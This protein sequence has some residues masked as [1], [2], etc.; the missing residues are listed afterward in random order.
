MIDK[1]SC[2]RLLIALPTFLWMTSCTDI[3]NTKYKD[4]SDLETP[5]DMEIVEKPGA[6]I[7]EKDELEKNGLADIVSYVNT[8]EKPVIKIKK[9][10]FRS[11]NI[12]EQALK[13]NNI[14]VKDK[15]RE[16]G[17]FYVLFDP[18]SQNSGFVD[19]IT[20]SLFE[21]KFEGD[22]YRLTVKWRDSDTEVR[23]ELYDKGG[24]DLLDDDED[25]D[26]FEGFVDESAKLLEILYKTISEDLPN[27]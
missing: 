3:S 8:E 22:A 24:S 23:A 12:V 9:L 1:K 13:L 20:F 19:A 4:T 6:N 14:K 11:W 21:D 7:T 16:L 15:N 2:F 10:F 25:N 26:D 18:D 5:P 27:N 17:V